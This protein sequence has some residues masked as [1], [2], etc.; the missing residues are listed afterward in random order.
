MIC[1]IDGDKSETRLLIDC[2][3]EYGGLLTSSQQKTLVEAY[4]RE[5]INLDPFISNF[6]GVINN[7]YDY[8][9]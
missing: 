9:W 2:K 3:I 1:R 8:E 6:N 5:Y 4:L 7:R